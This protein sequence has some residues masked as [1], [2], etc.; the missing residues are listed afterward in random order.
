[1]KEVFRRFPLPH[2]HMLEFLADLTGRADRGRHVTT[3][4][5]IVRAG[6]NSVTGSCSNCHDGRTADH[7][8]S[9]MIGTFP[10]RIQPAVDLMP[11]VS[12]AIF[13]MD[14]SLVIR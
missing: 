9:Q 3:N 8:P 11:A 7:D 13:V 12:E 10:G 5:S 2:S 6:H 14:Q 4:W 1:M